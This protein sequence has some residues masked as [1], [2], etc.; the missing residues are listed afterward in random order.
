MLDS[1]KNTKFVPRENLNL[2]AQF[3]DYKKQA[4]TILGAITTNIRSAGWEV[5]GAPFLITERRTRYI[6]GLDLQR[7]KKDTYSSKA[8]TEG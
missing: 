3:V 5:V 6:L 2:S 1:S 7:K 8:G 4:I